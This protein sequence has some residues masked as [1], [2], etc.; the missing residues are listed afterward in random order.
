MSVL[1]LVTMFAWATQFVERPFKGRSTSTIVIEVVPGVRNDWTLEG[2][3]EATHVGRFTNSGEGFTPYVGV[4]HGSGTLIAAD[5]D[6]VFWD[7]ET[8]SGGPDK[9]I[10]TG[11][12]GKFENASGTFYAYT[13]GITGEFPTFEYSYSYDGTITYRGDDDDDD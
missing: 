2:T 13:T 9:V 6:K 5:G 3:G 1:V 10:I 4:G 11:G 12:T 7:V 8:V